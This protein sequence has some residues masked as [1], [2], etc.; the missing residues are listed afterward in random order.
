M[1]RREQDPSY[2]KLVELD[3]ALPLLESTK[4]KAERDNDCHLLELR[5]K[6]VFSKGTC[7]DKLCSAKTLRSTGTPRDR[8]DVYRIAMM[9]MIAPNLLSHMLKFWNEGVVFKE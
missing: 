1:R 6:G 2:M 3:A 9:V 5:V 8:L 7:C 4:E